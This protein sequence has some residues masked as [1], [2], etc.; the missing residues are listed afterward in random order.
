ML[1]S[2]ASHSNKIPE[3]QLSKIV[4][5]TG[6]L[7]TCAQVQTCVTYLTQEADHHEQT[8]TDR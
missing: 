1:T 2:C 8:V 7:A 5:A 6:E 3:A 4:T